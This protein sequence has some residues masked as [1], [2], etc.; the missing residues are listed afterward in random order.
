ML[1]NLKL[2]SKIAFGFAT[3][4]GIA[5]ILGGVAIYNMENVSTKSAMLAEE[6]APEVEIAVDLRGAANRLMYNMRGYGLTGQET[7]YDLG[8]TELKNIDMSIAKGE[9]L[10]ETAQNLKKLSPQLKI[11]L[12][13]KNKYSDLITET[14]QANLRIIENKKILDANAKEYMLSANAVLLNQRNNYDK[15]IRQGATQNKLTERM[16]KVYWVNEVV[17]LGNSIRVATWK[18]QALRSTQGLKDAIQLF[19]QI[20]PIIQKILSITYQSKDKVEIGHIQTAGNLYKSAMQKIILENEN[21]DR[22]KL[23]REAAGQEVIDATKTIAAAGITATQNLA[24]DANSSLASASWIMIIGLISALIAGIVL[25]YIITT[26]ITK[27]IDRVIEDLSEGSTQVGSASSQVS[28]SSQQLAEGASEQASSLEEVSSTLEEISSM[29]R[30]NAQNSIEANTMVEDTGKAA[31]DCKSAMDQMS[32]A[33]NQIKTSSDET[34]KIVKD[35]DEIALQTNLLALNA[36]VE[37]ARAGEA[38]LGFAVVAEEVRNLAQRSAEAAKDTANLIKDGQK[39]AEQGVTVSGEVAGLLSSIVGSIEKVRQLIAEVNAASQEQSKGITQVN[40][41]VSQME[42][43]TQGNAANAEETASASEE[44]AAQSSSL[45]QIVSSLTLIV[46][47]DSDEGNSW[48]KNTFTPNT[49]R[50]IG[51]SL[52]PKNINK[53]STEQNKAHKMMPM[54]ESELR[55]F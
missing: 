49:L 39:N 28:S 23:Q 50:K 4:L 22:L 10:A 31:G 47:G 18:A 27:P 16:N 13:A 24:N 21:L 29:T 12:A 54:N 19:D 7:Y 5:L 42:Q 34:A 48:K 9:R 11:A 14:K 52:S 37:A 3:I 25:A 2:G 15:E 53:I 44:L 46:R 17:D 26:G 41:A 30:Q 40:Q 38:G 33:I 20:N 43:V 36:A 8:Q 6:Y 55:E 1:K 45:S 51:E 35:I 32:L